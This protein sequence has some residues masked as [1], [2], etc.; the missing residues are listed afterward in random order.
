MNKIQKISGAVWGLLIG[1]ALGVPY[2]FHKASEIPGY[3]DIDFEPPAG[4]S[5]SHSKVPSGTWSDDGAHALCLLESLV[6]C[7]ELNLHDLMEKLQ[8]WYDSGH[9]AVDNVVFDVGVQ[10][11]TA[12][13]TFS[14]GVNAECCG[15]ADVTDNGNGALMRVLPLA[16]WHAGSDEELVADAMRQSLVT[17]GHVRSQVCCALYSLWARYLLENHADPWNKSVQIL[18]ELYCHGSDEEEALEY[19]IRPDDE[20]Y[21]EGSGYVVDSLRSARLV[22]EAG[23]SYQDVVKKAIQLGNDTDTTACIAGG[24]AGIRYGVSGIPEQWR[25]QLRGKELFQPLLD[26]LVSMNSEY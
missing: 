2:E 1:D 10:T 15:P 7:N 26:R 25:E 6:S 12:L 4:F 19:Y 13:R 11:A 22:L 21:G 3:K 9:M 5:R 8:G 16:L 14:G 23:S 20:P 18:R 17:H 24:L